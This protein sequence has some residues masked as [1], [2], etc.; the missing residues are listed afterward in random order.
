MTPM[1][2]RMNWLKMAKP[3]ELSYMKRML[4]NTFAILVMTAGSALGLHGSSFAQVVTTDAVGFNV[5]DCPSGSDTILSVPFHQA[6]ALFGKVSGTPQVS[7]DEA[8]VNVA[9]SPDFT[10]GQ[11]TNPVHYLRFSSGSTR[12]GW[13]YR[14]I[15][16]DANSVNIDLDGDDLSGVVDG[17]SFE[18]IPYWTLANLFSNGNETIHKSS[19]LLLNQRETEIF[20]FDRESATL[21]LAPTRKFF[22][23][24]SGWREVA[25]GFPDADDVVV[26]PGASFVIR[27]PE[28]GQAT[29]FIAQQWV[30]DDD[31]AYV[32]AT[33]VA[34]T[35]DHHL[36][37]ARPV[38]VRL[39]DLDLEPPVFLESAS[40]D[41]GDRADELHV[42]DNTVAALNR[43]ASA[44][45]FRV[46]GQWV[47]DD[48]GFPPSNDV[49][50]DAGVGLM[51][52]KAP[53]ADGESLVWVNTPRY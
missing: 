51:I 52:R 22:Q 19:G 47:L 5:T 38:P 4:P 43:R 48:A 28:G 17:D 35:R 6:T 26:P 11:F 32:L 44:I 1:E 18:V 15:S 20:F 9:G 10:P 24:D 49:E 31:Q 40:N 13:G 2:I 30:N 23:T 53:T 46:N 29:R 25:R 42:F 50:I 16:H 45:Y 41:S 21:N 37:S 8:T 12:S 14:V 33:D 34:K 39:G 7:G 36:G 3:Q 27:H